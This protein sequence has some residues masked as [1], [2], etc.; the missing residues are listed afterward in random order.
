M[1]EKLY[2]FSAEA[3][4]CVL[5]RAKVFLFPQCCLDL[6]HIQHLYSFCQLEI[7]DAQCSTS[8]T[9]IAQISCSVSESI[10]FCV[11][12]N[13]SRRKHKHSPFTL[14]TLSQQIQPPQ[15]R[16][17]PLISWIYLDFSWG[18]ICGNINL[19]CSRK[20]NTNILLAS[21]VLSGRL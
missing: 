8:K 15:Q 9:E 20:G 3:L 16:T 10:S 2:N 11:R 1:F 7:H 21:V 5:G 19:V 12:K 17:N 18:I 6:K 4:T 13:R 14:I